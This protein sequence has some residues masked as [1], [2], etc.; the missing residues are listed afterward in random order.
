METL[1][2]KKR[3]LVASVLDAERGGALMLTEADIEELFATG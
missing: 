2:E 1:K 3:A